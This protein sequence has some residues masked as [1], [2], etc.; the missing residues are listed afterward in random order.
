MARTLVN[1]PRTAKR[2]EVIEIRA[3]IAHV[4]E[5]GFRAGSDGR[6]Q[7]RDIIRRFA[8]RY[9]GVPVFSAEL[10]PSISANPYI[11]FH[12]LATESG[13]LVFSWEG[14]NGFAQ[15][16]TLGLTVTG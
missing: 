7:P 1:M 9:N 12:T 4:M 15:S 14:D 8:C 6:Q 2:G 10:F 11:A 13:S 16:E 3:L 5:T